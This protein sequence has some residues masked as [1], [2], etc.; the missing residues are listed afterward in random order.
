MRPRNPPEPESRAAGEGCYD[1]AMMLNID[2]SD[3]KVVRRAPLF[4]GLPQHTLEMLLQGAT[5]K[6]ATRGELLFV[7]GDPVN[8]F[9]V[10]IDGWVK[11]YR[12]TP[13]GGEAVVAVFTR[14]QSF[15]EAAAFV[16]G[17]YPASGEAVTD[18]RLLKIQSGHLLKLI[19][20]N[21]DIGLAMLASTSM[22]LQMLVQQ[23]EQLKAHTGAQRVAEF[24]VSL[25]GEDQI[26][27][28]SLPYD[29]VLIAGRLG[30]Q[31]ESLSRAF[32]RLKPLGVRI[33]Q[34]TAFI[35]DVERLR[36]YAED[37]RTAGP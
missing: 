1:G 18:A 22:H 10:V 8:F 31:P 28:I 4:A 23:I 37:E 29:K 13:S 11:I 33:E 36:N 12:L 7:Q 27:R 34:N 32:A 20:D 5:V 14:G 6:V 16:G 15:A 2:P 35:D 21:P 24:L 25:C 19:R 30:M 3:V 17:R 9:Y 26:S